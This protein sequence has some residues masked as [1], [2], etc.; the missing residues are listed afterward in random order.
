MAESNFDQNT[1]QIQRALQDRIDMPPPPTP[2]RKKQKL[3]NESYSFSQK[4]DALI[5]KAKAMK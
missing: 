1:A 2:P 4:F 5:Q 3:Q